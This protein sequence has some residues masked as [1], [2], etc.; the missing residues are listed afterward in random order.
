MSVAGGEIPLSL[1][2]GTPVLVVDHDGDSACEPTD[3]ITVYGDADGQ[4]LYFNMTYA[5]ANVF[6][7][8]LSTLLGEPI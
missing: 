4:D 6:R 1:H 2:P 3:W 5:E 8:R 7:D